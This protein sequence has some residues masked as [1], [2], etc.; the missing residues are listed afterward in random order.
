[1][2]APHADTILGG[3]RLRLEEELNGLPRARRE[4]IIAEVDAHIR[5]ARTADA[6]E[7]D[8]DLLNLLDR[9]GDPSVIGTEARE[10]FDVAEPASAGG[11]EVIA[12]VLLVVGP[13]IVP[14][15]TWVLGAMLVWS[16]AAWSAREKRNSVA[17]SLIVI[18]GLTLI[19]IVIAIVNSPGT[20]VAVSILPGAVLLVVILGTLM[21][22]LS[23]L[24][25]AS[26]LARRRP[27]R[28]R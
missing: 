6:A 5:D 19:G 12:L 21:S 8:A 16:S 3:Y 18:V 13:F 9:L 22:V 17:W 20:T 25:L 27:R 24:L 14:V 28:A 11:R 15:V 7:T 2:S 26:A 10:R 23:G 1:M 4:E